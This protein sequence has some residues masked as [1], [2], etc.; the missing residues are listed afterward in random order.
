MG[1]VTDEART[2]GLVRP[3]SETGN[4]DSSRFVNQKTNDENHEAW[5]SSLKGT[6]GIVI[7]AR[8]KQQ[9][10][11]VHTRQNVVDIIAQIR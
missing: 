4:F 1:A 9:H 10:F 3:L 8:W 11:V 6:S 7:R 2:A 5:D